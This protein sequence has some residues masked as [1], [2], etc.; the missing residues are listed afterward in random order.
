MGNTMYSL[1]HNGMRKK[2]LADRIALE[3]SDQLSSYRGMLARGYMP[4]SYAF[5]DRYRDEFNKANAEMGS[6]AD[7][8]GSLVTV[9]EA[10]EIVQQLKA[11]VEPLHE[12]NEEVHRVI[13]LRTP[14]GMAQAAVLGPS[15]IL[16]GI[17]PLQ[18]ASA[19]LTELVTEKAQSEQADSEALANRCRWVV[20]LALCF[21]AGVGVLGL[22]IARSISATLRQSVSELQDGIR[23]VTDA[24]SQV[25]KSSD[26]LATDSS[27]QAASI[28]ETAASA[29]EINAMATQ[30]T[31]NSEAAAT[32]VTASN[33]TISQANHTL[34][35]MVQAMD[36]INSSSESVAKIV[37]LIDEISFQTNILSLNAAVEAARA[38]EAG[39]GFAV[40]ADEV[41]NLAQRSAQAAKETAN[42]IEDAISRTR[43]GKKKVGDMTTAFEEITRQSKQ[44]KL[45]VDQ[46]SAGGMEQSRGL[47]LISGN[48]QSM[49]QSTQGNAATA[50]ESA[51]AAQQLSAQSEAMMGVVIQLRQM[52][53]GK[54]A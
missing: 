20:G 21:G 52:V 50:E 36:G 45:L 2:F 47:R 23:E 38:G 53:E 54:A 30:N 19:R 24:A 28:E 40:V 42:L 10:K 17:T 6:T 5:V 51:A 39:M 27:K 22:K 15:R 44:V 34:G 1:S 12:A 31:G 13:C 4:N 14:E 25:A 37:K 33:E 48:I 3:L 26:A 49:E 18:K 16:L 8:L 32:L 41:R 11:G 9:P 29:T 7:E 46:I 43:T 35:E